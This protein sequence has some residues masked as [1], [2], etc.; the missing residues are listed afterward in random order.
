M[1]TLTL[2][3]EK[4]RIPT[5]DELTVK[6]FTELTKKDINIVNYLSVT[7]GINYKDAFNTKLKGVD[8]LLK[9]LGK[10]EDFTKLTPNKIVVDDKLIDIKKIDVSTVGQRFM[11][12]ENARSLNNEELLCFIL[13]IGVVDDPM[14]IEEIN[15]LKEK[16]LNEPY[17]KILPNAFFLASRF[18]IGRKSVMNYLKMCRQLINM[19]VKE[20]KRVLIDLIHIL[21]FMKFKRF[22]SY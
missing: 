3:K 4:K 5:M 11:I 2:N 21:T 14:N 6:Q 12:E 19:K 15:E 22:A 17:K 20:S 16:L 13:A 9:R 1:I 8:K 18:L 7:L 10:L